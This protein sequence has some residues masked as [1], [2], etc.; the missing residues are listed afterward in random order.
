[1][2]LK[3]PLKSLRST[4]RFAFLCWCEG[5]AKSQKTDHIPASKVTSSNFKCHSYFFSKPAI[6]NP[7]KT[8]N[9]CAE[10]N[11]NESMT[12]CTKRIFNQLKIGTPGV[13]DQVLKKIYQ[14]WTYAIM[15]F[16]SL[17]LVVIGFAS[18]HLKGEIIGSLEKKQ[19]FQLAL[20]FIILY[21]LLHWLQFVIQI[22]HSHFTAKIHSSMTRRGWVSIF[23]WGPASLRKD[24]AEHATRLLETDFRTYFLTT[25]SIHNEVVSTIMIFAMIAWRIHYDNFTEAIYIIPAIIALSLLA[26]MYQS[27]NLKS[28]AEEL[29]TESVRLHSWL[30]DY[31]ASA[32][33]AYYNWSPSGNS[34]GL[35]RWYEHQMDF[36]MGILERGRWIGTKRSI[37]NM[38]MIDLPYLSCVCAVFLA[39]AQ[40]RMGIGQA[41]VWIGLIESI[42]RAGS[43]F[44]TIRDLVLTRNATSNLIEK[45]L[46]RIMIH[47]QHVPSA[48]LAVACEAER[49]ECQFQLLDGTIVTLS[50]QRKLHQ[51]HGRNGSGKSTLLGFIAGQHENSFLW[52]QTELLRLRSLF[53]GRTRIISREMILFRSEKRFSAQILGPFYKTEE[54]WERLIQNTPPTLLSQGT[55]DRWTII[56]R[57]IAAKWQDRVAHQDTNLSSGERV[58]ISFIRALTCWDNNVRLLVV[59]ECDAVLDSSTRDLFLET[60]QEIAE[61]CSV[62]FI[63]H[64]N[65]SIGSFQHARDRV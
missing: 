33:E 61:Q 42:I 21:F 59:D 57:S 30:R 14:P 24:S 35:R 36:L 45:A 13:K 31:H 62:Y 55:R 32:H 65:H 2:L 16:S 17:S 44:K 23:P 4:L 7:Y 49:L 11:F 51:I 26:Q 50:N 19:P 41:I 1:M 22:T 58:I 63:S 5:L 8:S 48:S 39:V 43:S 6:C 60:L 15:A 64:T 54:D 27:K 37:A 29:G 40:N 28:N 20:Q 46:Q 25:S 53:Q 3:L 47:P 34:Q 56:L 52:N 12:R 10:G 38:M 9:Q 18:L